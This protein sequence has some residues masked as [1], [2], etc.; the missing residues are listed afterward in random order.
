[1][2][3][4]SGNAFKQK[5][6]SVYGDSAHVLK[7]ENRKNEGYPVEV[8]AIQAGSGITVQEN[9]N[10]ITIH[11]D[12]GEG[13][14][15]QWSGEDCQSSPAANDW[16]AYVVDSYKRGVTKAKFRG[17]DA[18]DGIQ[19][20]PA[21]ANGIGST[22]SVEIKTDLENCGSA[23]WQAYKGVALGKEQFRGLNAGTGIYFDTD[24]DGCV[25]TISRSCCTGTDEY[26]LKT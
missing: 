11:R 12:T 7:A 21:T 22:C 24:D 13:S 1:M 9:D 15:P 14:Y 18:G 5:G 23:N 2:R 8:R 25:T 4:S 20:D 6:N 3:L 19:F 16:T 17:L 10:Y 26:E